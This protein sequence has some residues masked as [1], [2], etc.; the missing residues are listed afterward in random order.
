MES[1][2]VSNTESIKVRAGRFDNCLKIEFRRSDLPY[3]LQYYYYAPGVGK[4]LT[5][6]SSREEKKETRQ[7][8]LLS[9]NIPQMENSK[10]KVQRSKAEE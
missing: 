1:V 5:T 8:E 4:I 2:V 9:Y 10:S 7:T 3:S 6:T